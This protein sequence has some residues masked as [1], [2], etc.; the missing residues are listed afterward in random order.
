[1][2][3]ANNAP[4]AVTVIMGQDGAYLS[5]L[6]L[7]MATPC[8]MYRRTRFVNFWRIEELGIH[9]HPALHLGRRI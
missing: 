8:S 7:S 1:M 3:S 2:S 9:D 4:I 5:E 6:L